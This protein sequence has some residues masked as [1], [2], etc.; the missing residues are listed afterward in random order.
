MGA[1]LAEY[2][3]CAASLDCLFYADCISFCPPGDPICIDDCGFFYPLGE[4]M[5]ASWEAC[6]CN[7]CVADCTGC[8]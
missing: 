8:P 6:I 7:E 4:S 3:A 1:C 5:Y 2:D